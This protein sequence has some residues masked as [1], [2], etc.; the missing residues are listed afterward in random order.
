VSNKQMRN[1]RTT[2]SHPLSNPA[3]STTGARTAP[4]ASARLGLDRPIST[5]L[6]GAPKK[7]QPFLEAGRRRRPVRPRFSEP[8]APHASP[9][10]GRAPRK[11]LPR[12]AER[13]L[14]AP[15]IERSSSFP[16]EKRITPR[17]FLGRRS[18]RRLP[19]CA[20][21]ASILK[22]EGHNGQRRRGRPQ[23]GRPAIP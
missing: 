14:N 2:S 21:V 23:G 17:L 16:H 15:F 6:Y 20:T 9:S 8:S 19:L 4:A 10:A 18:C 5:A 3:N 7:R 1:R 22:T 11:S 12:G 13:R